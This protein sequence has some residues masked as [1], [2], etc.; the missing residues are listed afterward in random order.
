M[1][2]WFDEIASR[3]AP[4]RPEGNTWLLYGDVNVGLRSPP[5][6][7]EIV[8]ARPR[9]RLRNI[10]IYGLDLLEA[11]SQTISSFAFTSTSV[12]SCRNTEGFSVVSQLHFASHFDGKSL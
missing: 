5:K 2:Y 7:L 12:G 10:A 9:K 4:T 6:S 8:P 3:A 11:E 1:P